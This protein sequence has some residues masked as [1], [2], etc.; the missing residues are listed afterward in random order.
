MSS[1]FKKTWDDLFT[2]ITFAEA[3]E[4]ETARAILGKKEAK[5]A[6]TAQAISGKPAFL[7]RLSPLLVPIINLIIFVKTVFLTFLHKVK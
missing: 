4:A 1:K 3:N 7:H 6:E 5:E 2:A